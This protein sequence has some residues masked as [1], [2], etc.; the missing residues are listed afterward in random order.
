[1]KS[2]V[3]FTYRRVA[4]FV[5]GLKL[6]SKACAPVHTKRLLGLN[7]KRSVVLPAP[8]RSLMCSPVCLALEY[9]MPMC[10]LLGAV[11]AAAQGATL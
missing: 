8:T 3:W 10:Y 11:G 9:Q 1:M 6:I 7:P 4:H 2:Y 5:D